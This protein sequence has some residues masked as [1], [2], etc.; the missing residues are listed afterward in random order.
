[1]AHDCGVGAIIERMKHER[2]DPPVRAWV[3]PVSASYA[4]C[5]RTKGEPIDVERAR[6]QHSAYVTLLERSGI[7]I[8]HVAV[9]DA[10]PDCCFIEDTAVLWDGGGVL[11]RP[12]AAS[13]AREVSAVGHTLAERYPT[14]DIMTPPA[15]LDGGDV[16]RAGSRLVVGLSTRTSPAGLAA[17]GAA[18]ERHGLTV[19]GVAVASGLH[20]KSAATMLDQNTALMHDEQAVRAGDLA[21]LGLEVVM[22]PEPAGSNVLALGDRVIVSAAAPKTAALID[23][24]GFEALS[25]DISELH[26]GDGALTCLS[27]RQ[28]PPGS[29]CV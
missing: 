15:T 28:P 11:T 17:L 12:G 24:L 20:L 29:W 27:L 4:D 18:A 3:R 22:V 8:A 16:M 6:R 9:D 19:C 2:I 1:M 14:L 25:V 10:A 26:R 21:E 23:E 7:A 5:I 13:R